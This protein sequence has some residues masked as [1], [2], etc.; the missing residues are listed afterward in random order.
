MGT[1]STNFFFYRRYPL[2]WSSA[3]YIG[4]EHRL[5]HNQR[6]IPICRYLHSWLLSERAPHAVLSHRARRPLA[7]LFD[8]FR[9]GVPACGNHPVGHLSAPASGRPSMSALQDLA[10]LDRVI[11]EP[12]RLMVMTILYAVPEADFIYLQNECGL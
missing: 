5:G 2:V 12:V 4:Y 1:V 7:L 9:I 8:R 6:K 11:H 3:G 10:S